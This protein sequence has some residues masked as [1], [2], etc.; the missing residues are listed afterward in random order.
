MKGMTGCG[1]DLFHRRGGRKG[2]LYSFSISVSR[3]TTG[4]VN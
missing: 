4:R 1:T 2:R 3:R